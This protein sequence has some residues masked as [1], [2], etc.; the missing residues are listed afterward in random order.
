MEHLKM[1][2][3]RARGREYDSYHVAFVLY[4]HQVCVCVGGGAVAVAQESQ[5]SL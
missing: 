4:C 2:V 1:F 3:L 5:S